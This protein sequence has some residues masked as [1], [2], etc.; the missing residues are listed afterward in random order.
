MDTNDLLTVYRRDGR[1]V[2]VLGIDQPGLVKAWQGRLAGAE[3]VT[4][5]AVALPEAG[6][7]EL[8]VPQA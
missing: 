2:A 4:P 1:P 8:A 6:T 7:P 5:G 3:A